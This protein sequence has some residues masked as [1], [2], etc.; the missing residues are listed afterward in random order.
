LGGVV[1]LSP[2]AVK[3][4]AAQH[5]FLATLACE[6]LCGLAGFIFS[7]PHAHLSGASGKDGLSLTRKAHSMAEELLKELPGSGEQPQQLEPS[8]DQ[9]KEDQTEKASRSELLAA[10]SLFNA[11]S[12]DNTAEQ[13]AAEDALREAML[14]TPSRIG[15]PDRTV[16]DNLPLPCLPDFTQ[17]PRDW[18]KDGVLCVATESY[19]GPCAAE[20][21]LTEMSIEQKLAFASSCSAAFP[22]QEECIQDFQQACPSLWREVGA[23]ICNAPLEYEGSCSVRLDVASMSEEEKYT[24]ST[25]CGARWPCTSIK[26]R[27]YDDVCPVGWTL[28]FGR[29]CTAPPSYN[30]PCERTAHMSGASAVN[31]KAFEASCHVQWPEMGGECTHDYGAPCPF[32]WYQTADECVAPLTY[33]VCSRRK[34]FA[35]MTP[36]A[37][38]DWARN[39]KVEFPCQGRELCTKAYSA[40]C[41]AEWFAFNGGM[42][43]SAPSH[44]AGVCLPV[45]HGLLDI[46]AAEK[47]SLEEKCQFH[48]PCA[49]EVYAS[50][51]QAT[52]GVAEPRLALDP[53]RYST[54]EGPIE[55]AS[56]AIKGNRG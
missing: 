1:V 45:L 29:T 38:E 25:R 32:A 4:M 28:Q 17:C 2:R 47:T 56:G 7:P 6:F 43:C 42:S 55:G 3:A 41:P 23:S 37:K 11:A 16:Q 35:T 39:C 8:M 26:K 31:K 5:L 30:G 50:I 10:T 40:P 22:C 52:G 53:A 27:S 33:G 46:T 36:A 34:S 54:A 15:A 48:W 9:V 13:Q 21:D 24:W 14:S 44:Y 19:T 51:L 12:S 49:G 20:A 18:V